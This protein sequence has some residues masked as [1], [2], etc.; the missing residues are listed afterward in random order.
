MP[1]KN[2]YT[3]P[4]LLLAAVLL[5]SA[6]SNTKK[7][8]EGDSLYLGSSIR[9]T[10]KAATKKERKF[11]KKELN[12]VVRPVPNKK[13][14]G[15]RIKLRMYN[16]AGEPKKPKGFK[17]WLRNKVGEP[18]VL[19]SSVS[20][21]T[22]EK[23]L[24]N[25]LQNRG[26]F[27]SQV[28]GTLEVKKKKSQTYFDVTTGYQYMIRETHF[29]EDSATAIAREIQ[30]SS[31]KTLLKKG[32]P[33]NLDLIKGERL[34]IEKDLKE[35]GYYYFK[36]DYL[37]ILADTTVGDHQVDM[38][39]R[40]KR[41]SVPDMAYNTYRIN[42]IYLYTNYQLNRSSIDTNLSTAVEY[43]GLHIVDRRKK[44]RPFLFRDMLVFSSG[45][46]YNRT[47][48]NTSIS[49][50]INLN[51]FKFV[52][53]R[54]EPVGDSMLD[55]Y[56][57][58]SPFPKK[59]LRFEIGAN[60]QNDS[61]AGSEISVSWRNRNTFKAAEE[62]MVKLNG[63]FESQY[64]G[65]AKQP[66]IYT[67]GGQIGFSFPYFVV[68]FAHIRSNSVVVPRTIVKALYSY[69]SQQG[70]LRINSYKL[71]YGYSWKETIRKEHQ[72]YPININYVKT[73][74]FSSQTTNAT[75]ANLLF[76]GLIIG[77]TYEFTYN[78]QVGSSS[79]DNYYFDGLADFSG[80]I[81][82]AAQQ[83][84]YKT[85]PRQILGQNYAQYAKFQTDFRYYHRYPNDNI[86]ANR[87]L[88]GAGLPYGNSAQLPNIKQFFSGGNS[89]LRGFRSRMMGPGTFNEKYL[90][91]TTNYIQTLG[92][93]KLELNTEW[94][95]NVYKFFKIGAFADAGNIWLYNDNPAF[96]G[97]KFS[98]KFLRELGVDV[99]LGFRFDFKILLLRLDAA[100]PVRKPWLPE[101]ERWVFKQIDFGTPEWRSDNLIFNLAI[102]YPF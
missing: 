4:L 100:I 69:E 32:A 60:T 10:D 97:G 71:S 44:Y 74:T 102:G 31:S 95:I 28:Q 36:P 76:N 25:V 8:P 78:S 62:F 59:S 73:D 93:L 55:A 49:R 11:L 57:Y 29:M 39:M 37:Y 101:G 7:L 81:I 23:L 82:G 86:W 52:K 33:Y 46:L 70:L 18:P 68:P 42:D 47:T 48:Q 27:F 94:R 56:Y 20:L 58:L 24:Q 6:C 1:L 91:G 66:S 84:D 22:N 38:R 98:S 14:L 67:V 80:V 75:Y 50:L 88:I 30:A 83:A 5:L 92:D 65:I 17:N 43:K 9:I 16:F 34:R 89:S 63:G 87:I 35:K 79:P 99:G 53:N 13:T 54:F 96:P 3:T 77:P 45:D 64:T 41:D 21:P 85:N 15:M 72:L 26:Y 12:G 61:R 19:A 90:E 2:L 51:T 40:V